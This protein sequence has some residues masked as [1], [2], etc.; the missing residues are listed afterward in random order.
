VVVE[1]ELVAGVMPW[2]GVVKVVGAKEAG[3]KVVG[4]VGLG[5]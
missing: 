2:V 4:V 5:A 3:V 1:K